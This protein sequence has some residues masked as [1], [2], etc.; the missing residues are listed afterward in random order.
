[1]RQ[2]LARAKLDAAEEHARALRVR[3]AQ[4]SQDAAAHV[5]ESRDAATLVDQWRYAGELGK[6]LMTAE[7]EV[8]RVAVEY[9]QASQARIEASRDVEVLT[10]LREQS[11]QLHRREVQREQQEQLNE[12]AYQRWIASKA[13]EADGG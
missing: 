12:Q 2:R 4:V 6:A 9:Q 13:G 8:A 10:A 1:M 5:G 3:L 11:W 7:A